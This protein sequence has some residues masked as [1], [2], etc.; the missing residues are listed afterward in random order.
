MGQGD[1]P[2]LTAQTCFIGYI[3]ALAIAIRFSGEQAFE[4]H[5]PNTQLYAAY[6]LLTRAGRDYFR[7]LG[8][9]DSKEPHNGFHHT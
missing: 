4:L 7:F 8:L 9:P 1:F 2:W 6:D 3:E 5:I